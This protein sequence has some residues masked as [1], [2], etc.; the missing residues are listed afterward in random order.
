MGVNACVECCDRWVKGGAVAL[1][2]YGASGGRQT[3][4]FAQL[5]DDSARFAN[6]LTS[7][8]IGQ[9][10][11]VAG[12]LPRI[13]DLM[14]VILGAWRVGAVYQPLFTAFGPA[15]VESRVTAQ[16]GSQAKLIVTDVSNRPKLNDVADCPPTLVVGDGFADMLALQSSEF[17]PVMVK[18]TG[19]FTMLRQAQ[20]RALSAVTAAAHRRLHERRCR[21]AA[22]RCLL[23]RGRS[24][25]GLWHALVLAVKQMAYAPMRLAITPARHSP[26]HENVPG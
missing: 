9:G 17:A 20:G 21:S 5:K 14:T 2:W 26:D 3:V 22:D 10:D 24:R 19:A 4:T 6:Y 25:L 23:E 16:G 1:E 13:P 7:L 12:L 8:G 11:V 18:G 15:A